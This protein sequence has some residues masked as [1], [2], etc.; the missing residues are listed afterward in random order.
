MTAGAHNMNLDRSH[1]VSLMLIQIHNVLHQP[2][3]IV[4][5][6]LVLVQPEIAVGDLMPE[7]DFFRLRQLFTE[8]TAKELNLNVINSHIHSFYLLVLK[9]C[10]VTILHFQQA[11]VSRPSPKMLTG[12]LSFYKRPIHYHIYCIYYIIKIFFCQ[13]VTMT[14]HQVFHCIPS[15][16][17]N[18]TIWERFTHSQ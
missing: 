4:P 18:I 8:V 11:L 2:R 15:P 3:S 17:P 6:N 9:F 5:S 14:V 1:I 13:G 7:E 10:V 12:L 16:Y